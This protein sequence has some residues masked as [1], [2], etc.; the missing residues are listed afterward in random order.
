M[1]IKCLNNL[2]IQIEAIKY[3][4]DFYVTRFKHIK[5]LFFNYRIYCWA[6]SPKEWLTI[7]KHCICYFIRYGVGF[8]IS[9]G[10]NL[11]ARVIKKEETNEE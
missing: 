7:W 4:I 9:L 5:N 6:S 3:A 2:K 8:T 1:R 11:I 10:G